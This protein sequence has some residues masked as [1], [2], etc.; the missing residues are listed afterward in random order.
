MTNKASSF[1]AAPAIGPLHRYGGRI[2]ALGELPIHSLG[3]SFTVDGNGTVLA[4]PTLQ[5]GVT[6]FLTMAGTP[7]FKN[8]RVLVCPG[9]VD[10]VATAGD[11]VIARSKDDGVW[12]L[13]LVN[14]TKMAPNTIKGN[15]TGG[16]ASAAD[17][18][19]A[20]I[21]AM[22]TGGFTLRPMLLADATY[23]V[24]T[25][26]SDST[27]NGT[28]GAPWRTIQHAV[29]VAVSYDFG[30]H[31]VTI[32]LADGTYVES[33]QLLP[34][35][36][37]AGQGHTT[38]T[39]NG[40]AT[41][42]GNVIIQP[43][44]GNA[45]VGVETGGFEWL[46][47]NLRINAAGATGIEADAGSWI[48]INNVQFGAATLHM[49]VLYDGKLEVVGSYSIVGSAFAHVD[50]TSGGRF[51]VGASPTVTLTGTPAFTIF[52]VAD[53]GGYL[54]FIGAT[55][56]GAAT[57]QRYSATSGATIDTN[58]G[59]TNYFPGSTAGSSATGYYL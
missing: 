24:S 27:G 6:I 39:I 38:P 40:N 28:S 47:S 43:A 12:Q 55:F 49:Q 25:T 35:I 33:L 42:P 5:P 9:G 2:T 48:T 4:L 56:S 11:L 51:L 41:T 16:A 59:N 31:N 34:Y 18:T 57:G 50:V 20:Q 32:Q 58:T 44:S 36:G 45:I 29:N 22:L 46:I 7:T 14:P 3:D 30:G 53:K 8:S 10:Y 26:G 13:Y 54:G 52:A 17:L 21:L 23:F 19:I 1:P 37:R 15:N